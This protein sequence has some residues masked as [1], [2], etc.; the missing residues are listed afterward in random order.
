MTKDKN[1]VDATV[2]SFSFLTILSYCHAKRHMHAGRREVNDERSSLASRPPR[3]SF[4]HTACLAKLGSAVKRVRV[5]P[6]MEREKANDVRLVADNGRVNN[7]VS[8]RPTKW[9]RSR[10]RVISHTHA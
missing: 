8:N 9:S 4:C 6:I 7:R 10:F 3:A 1:S 5:A 2:A